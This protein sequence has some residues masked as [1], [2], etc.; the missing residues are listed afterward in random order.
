MRYSTL[1]DAKIADDNKY[2]I[3]LALKYL[4]KYFLK[5]QRS[6]DDIKKQVDEVLNSGSQNIQKQYN[7]LAIQFYKEDLEVCKQINDFE[8]SS[9][10]YSSLGGCSISESEYQVSLNYYKDSYEIASVK[11]DDSGL[12]YKFFAIIGI[13]NSFSLMSKKDQDKSEI[14]LWG[15]R[16]NE[17]GPMKNSSFPGMK[18][19]D[20]GFIPLT[21][22][23]ENWAKVFAGDWLDQLK[24]HMEK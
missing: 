24:G 23:V 1:D 12:D 2:Y 8:G 14:D 6:D 10:M 5:L 17:L 9:M 7:Q 18:D 11:M 3:E 19:G 16:L 15:N 13:L 20:L 22:I 4:D 21:D